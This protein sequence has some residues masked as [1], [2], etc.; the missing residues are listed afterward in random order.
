MT[1]HHT[2]TQR[3]GATHWVIEEGQGRTG[4]RREIK[5]GKAES[6]RDC[7]FSSDVDRAFFTQNSMVQVHVCIHVALIVPML[8]RGH[9]FFPSFSRA[10]KIHVR[11]RG[12]K[13]MYT[14]QN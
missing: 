14:S 13:P 11:G 10:Y 12:L 2:D 5:R 1:P 3:K 7:W 9:P 8:L 6:E 4:E